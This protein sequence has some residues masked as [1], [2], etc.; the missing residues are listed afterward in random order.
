MNKI[1]YLVIFTL[2]FGSVYAMTTEQIC[3]NS[4]HLYEE[5]KLE[6]YIDGS[7]D[8]IEIWNKT[9]ECNYG[10]ENNQ[11]QTPSLMT[12]GMFSILGLISIFLLG[13]S[14]YTENKFFALISSM[15]ILIMGV[16]VTTEGIIVDGIL[17][18]ETVI[19]IIGIIMIMFSI[20]LIYSFI[21]DEAGEK[22]DV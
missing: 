1:I 5:I 15:I 8:S 21:I 11:C 14:S 12:A 18:K 4:T 16:Y 17:F 13:L 22:E 10:C 6:H 7:L 9:I 2:F 19:R 20:Y 3:L